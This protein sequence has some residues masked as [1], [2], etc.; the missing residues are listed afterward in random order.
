MERAIETLVVIQLAVIGL[1]HIIHHRAWVDFFLWLR[2]KGYP[3]VFANG[4]L[5]LTAGSLIVAFHRVWSGIPLVLTLFGILNLAKAAQCFLLPAVALRSMN[6]VSHDRSRE[7]V[8]A[9][10]VALLLAALFAYDLL[11]GA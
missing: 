7:F 5:S 6:R 9:G 4:F 11:R 1:S 8:G 10:V 3:G 2:E